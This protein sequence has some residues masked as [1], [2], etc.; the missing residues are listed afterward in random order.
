[1]TSDPKSIRRAE[2][3]IDSEWGGHRKFS[4]FRDDSEREEPARVPEETEAVAAPRR[5]EHHNNHQWDSI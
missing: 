2:K 1:M 3:M 5:K 4:S